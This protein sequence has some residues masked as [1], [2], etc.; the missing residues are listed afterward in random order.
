MLLITIIEILNKL[1]IFEYHRT[2]KF[3]S[4]ANLRKQFQFTKNFRCPVIDESEL[5]TA[6][7]KASIYLLFKKNSLNS[8]LKLVL[9]SLV[10]T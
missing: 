6:F 10:H 5:T 9:T 2:R 1:Q 7:F 3:T 8:I 4:N